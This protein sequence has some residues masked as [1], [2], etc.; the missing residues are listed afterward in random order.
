MVGDAKVSNLFISG[1][2]VTVAYQLTIR[3]GFRLFPATPAVSSSQVLSFTLFFFLARFA[4]Q[5]LQIYCN[6]PS[7]LCFS[8]PQSNMLQKNPE[9]NSL[10]PFL[11]AF[12]ATAP[13]R[14]SL[15]TPLFRGDISKK[16]SVIFWGAKKE[17]KRRKE[18]K[19]PVSQCTC[20][21]V[22]PPTPLVRQHAWASCLNLAATLEI[23]PFIPRWRLTALVLCVSYVALV[24]TGINCVSAVTRDG[25][26]A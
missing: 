3:C 7:S 2:I 1:R 21:R 5:H 13:L 4:R 26:R 23:S 24:R 8:S 11:S 16:R 18:E 10:L 12:K 25:C 14:L 6:S 20:V 15:V 19:K 17:K 9:E 22:S